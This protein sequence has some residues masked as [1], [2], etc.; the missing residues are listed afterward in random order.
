MQFF[1]KASLYFYTIQIFRLMRILMEILR[2]IINLQFGHLYYKQFCRFLSI[3]RSFWPIFWSRRSFRGCWWCRRCVC[4][5]LG[6][7]SYTNQEAKSPF[8]TCHIYSR[9]SCTVHQGFFLF[10]YIHS[11]FRSESL[12]H[13]GCNCR[14]LS[15]IRI[16]W[17]SSCASIST[18]LPS[19]PSRT[20]CWGQLLS[21][22]LKTVN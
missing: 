3:G 9:T 13:F 22:P 20:F 14:S 4:V 19:S 11:L 16:G 1:L 6:A 17:C 2:I 18:L 8:P 12:T 21:W 15:L 7:P 10:D 5:Q